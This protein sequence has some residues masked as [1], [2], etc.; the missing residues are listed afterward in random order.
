MTYRQR[1]AIVDFLLVLACVFLFVMIC[2]V[3]FPRKAHAH[4][5]GTHQEDSLANAKSDAYGLCCNGQDWSRISTWE[6]TA[7]GYRIMYKGEWLEGSRRV[8]VNNMQNPDGEA[9]AWIYFMDDK[10]YIRCF[11]AG[12]LG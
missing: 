9:K 6:T 4:D 1:R 11:M 2:V 3:N 5:P 10:P 7:T 8:K 12:A